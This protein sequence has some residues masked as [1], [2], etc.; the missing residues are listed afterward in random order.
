MSVIAAPAPGADVLALIAMQLGVARQ[1][2]KDQN[3]EREAEALRAIEVYAAGLRWDLTE[4]DPGGAD[5]LLARF[6]TDARPTPGGP[7]AA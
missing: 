1:A 3:A 2:E 4:A 7:H 6:M 5:D